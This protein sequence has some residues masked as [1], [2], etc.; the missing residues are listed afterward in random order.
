MNFG[1]IQEFNVSMKL[2]AQ[3]TNIFTNTFFQEHSDILRAVC[4]HDILPPGTLLVALVKIIFEAK[5]FVTQPFDD[6]HR[7]LLFVVAHL[8]QQF[9]AKS[10]EMLI[11]ILTTLLKPQLRLTT[12][13]EAFGSHGL[14]SDQSVLGEHI[15]EGGV[16][17]ADGLL[18][19]HLFGCGRQFKA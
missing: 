13:R 18:L 15:A 7:M 16:K 12:Q 2:F 14:L 8:L 6:A 5:D 17:I 19:C 9:G 4:N 10:A 3:I 1:F 11:A